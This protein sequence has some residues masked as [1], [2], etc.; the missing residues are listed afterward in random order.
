MGDE[1]LRALERAWQQTGTIE[2]EARLLRA[3]LR[4]G[5]LAPERLELAAWLGHAPAIEA[6]G[7]EAPA[8]EH[9]P[10]A[11]W[12]AALDAEGR[13]VVVGA[14]LEQIA[15]DAP[16]ALGELVEGMRRALAHWSRDPTP[17]RLA[18]VQALAA[19]YDGGRFVNAFMQ[20]ANRTSPAYLGA[21]I[22]IGQLADAL[23]AP[24]DPGSELWAEALI[25]VWPDPEPRVRSWLA[26]LTSWAL[27]LGH[28]LREAA[29][30]PQLAREAA[31]LMHGVVTGQLTEER[32]CFAALLGYAPARRALAID[33]Q[34]PSCP[35]EV[36]PW[37]EELAG[38][39]TVLAAE[40]LLW[41]LE[42]SFAHAR[43]EP[44]AIDSD[45]IAQ[46]FDS[47]P[48]HARVAWEARQELSMVLAGMLARA[49]L[50]R[51]A[52]TVEDG[53][54]ASGWQLSSEER[55]ELEGLARALRAH[56]DFPRAAR[57]LATHLELYPREVTEAA[58]NAAR[59]HVLG[60]AL[61]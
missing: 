47:L 13:A 23:C 27:G 33:A 12:A 4:A 61:R 56:Q 48:E 10:L 18:A 32:L 49:D 21:A 24:H 1:D 26:R 19:E 34:P 7:P 39:D 43:S 55:G 9:V 29:Q 15:L 25:E 17:E 51:A 52:A 42:E 54:R 60:R 45:G 50:S 31:F 2:A 35:V 5:A 30:P 6:L 53:L 57:A 58:V 11:R 3:R 46:S 36:V 37:L 14:R 8:G 38:R 40:A 20:Q 59:R 41:M 16:A 44:G 28:V 22:Q